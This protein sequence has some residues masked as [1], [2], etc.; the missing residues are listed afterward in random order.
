MP[1]KT[2]EKVPVQGTRSTALY[3]ARDA[4]A[5]TAFCALNRVGFSCLQGYIIYTYYMYYI[6][7]LIS[8]NQSLAKLRE[9]KKFTLI[10]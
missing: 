3:N 8:L 1:R 10:N 2:A 9:V 7:Y 6:K 5:V 4:D